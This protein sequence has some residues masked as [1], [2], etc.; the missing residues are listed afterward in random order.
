MSY[1]SAE[2]PKEYRIAMQK[3]KKL[4]K[5]RNAIDLKMEIIEKKLSQYDIL[6]GAYLDAAVDRE[7]ADEMGYNDTVRFI[8]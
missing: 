6:Q 5:E 1:K 7:N 2:K 3:L 8:H 4:E